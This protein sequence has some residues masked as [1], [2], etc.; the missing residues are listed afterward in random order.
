MKV[1][2][3]DVNDLACL[4]SVNTKFIQS[5]TS[6]NGAVELKMLSRKM[7]IVT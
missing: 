1:S 2:S 7:P 5:R 4:L 3:A 6:S